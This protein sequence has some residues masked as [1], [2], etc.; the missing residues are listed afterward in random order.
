L[1]PLRTNCGIRR[2]EEEVRDWGLDSAP[3]AGGE[4]LAKD[5]RRLIEGA[6]AMRARAASIAADIEPELVF[7]VRRL[8]FPSSR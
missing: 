7:A 8:F 5:A 6:V 1:S 3:D 4:A 2:Q